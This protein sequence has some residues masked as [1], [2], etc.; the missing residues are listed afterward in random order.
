MHGIVTVLLWALVGI[1]K[2]AA[3]VLL[4]ESRWGAAVLAL[5]LTGLMVVVALQWRRRVA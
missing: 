5:A 3:L 1:A 4:I 2:I